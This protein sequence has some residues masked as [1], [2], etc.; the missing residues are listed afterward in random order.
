V[1]LR[2]DFLRE[3]SQTVDRLERPDVFELEQCLASLLERLKSMVGG[4]VQEEDVRLRRYAVRYRLDAR[5]H[6]LSVLDV[7]PI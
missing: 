3:A 6:S 1:D 5:D 7:S 2:I 4:K